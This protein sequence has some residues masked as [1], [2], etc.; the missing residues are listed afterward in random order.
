[1]QQ[2]VPLMPQSM[3]EACQPSLGAATWNTERGLKAA[4]EYQLEGMRFAAKRAYCNLEFMRRL[5][6][7]QGWQEVLQ[8]QQAWWSGAAADYAEE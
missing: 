4:L 7:C 3:L 8:L 1:M 5:R 2:T 6:H